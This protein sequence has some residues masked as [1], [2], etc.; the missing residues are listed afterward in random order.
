MYLVEYA[1]CSYDSHNKKI[2]PLTWSACNVFRLKMLKFKLIVV[3]SVELTYHY[4]SLSITH[5]GLNKGVVIS[6]T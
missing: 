4:N 2:D 3:C 1:S 5:M 6:I